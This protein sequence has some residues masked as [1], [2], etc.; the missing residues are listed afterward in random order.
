MKSS[1]K[2]ILSKYID[3]N[4]KVSAIEFIIIDGGA[5]GASMRHEVKS[6]AWIRDV[7]PW[8][9]EAADQMPDEEEEDKDD[10]KS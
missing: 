6:K 1:N 7:I 10:A 8:L 4:K 5:Q 2:L 9:Q 3:D